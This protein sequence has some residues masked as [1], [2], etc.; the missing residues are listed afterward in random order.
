MQSTLSKWRAQGLST[1][2][3]G[4]KREGSSFV[5]TMWSI[6]GRASS[7]TSLWRSVSALL[8]VLSTWIMSFFPG[9]KRLRL[10]WEVLATCTTSLTFLILWCNL[11]PAWLPIWTK[12]RNMKKLLTW[13]TLI[14]QTNSSSTR[15]WHSRW[16]INLVAT[17]IWTFLAK[18][19]RSPW[20]SKADKF[21]TSWGVQTTTFIKLPLKSSR[22]TSFEIILL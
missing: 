12:R 8:L 21:P 11:E 16:Q 1:R 7:S 5:T 14:C 13:K 9:I 10:S 15:L 2:S 18:D 17:K 3:G 4:D 6:R 19:G 20:S 22:E